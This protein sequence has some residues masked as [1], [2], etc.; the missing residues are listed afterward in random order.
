MS[1]G[2]G[3]VMGRLSVALIVLLSLGFGCTSPRKVALAPAAAPGGD[4]YAAAVR[5]ASSDG[6]AVWIETDLAKRWLQ[7]KRAFDVAEKR[8]ASLARLPGVMGVK[9]ADELGYDDGF[10]GRAGLMRAFVRDA[11]TALHR[12]APGRS[13]LV[14]LVV[15]QLGCLPGTTTSAALSCRQSA[16]STHPGLELSNVDALLKTRAIDVLDLSTGLLSGSQYAAMGTTRDRAQAAAWKEVTRRGW[17]SLVRLNARKA[18]AHPG[19]YSGNAAADTATFLAI[20]LR[21]GAHAVDV[22]TWRQQYKGQVYRLMD[23]GA[24]SNA[25]WRALLARRAA[26]DY[27]LTHFSPSSVDTTLAADLHLISTVFRGVFVAAGTG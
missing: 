2:S 19:G 27:L 1:G 4:K 13:I 8:V 17:P 25:L 26:G 18:L 15:P 3:W 9:I 20:P 5:V 22:W 14:D 23:P 11:A 12:D 24:V 16:A 21:E 10:A 7:G 6:L